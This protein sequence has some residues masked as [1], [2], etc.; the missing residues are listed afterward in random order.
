MNIPEQTTAAG[1]VVSM[2]KPS[3]EGCVFG[4]AHEISRAGSGTELRVQCRRYPPQMV[5]TPALLAGGKPV[6]E[7]MMP[8]LRPESWC[9]EWVPRQA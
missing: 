1:K 7:V 9:G 6:I 5:S 4:V 2:P 3:C 8:E